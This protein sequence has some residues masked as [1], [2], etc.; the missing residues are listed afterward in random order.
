M[1]SETAEQSE[2]DATVW[3]VTM[4]LD[5]YIAGVDGAMNWVAGHG[6]AGPVADEI[7]DTTGAILAGRRWHDTAM[8][9]FS[10]R[11]GIY[12]GN[13]DGPVLV[14]TH[15]PPSDPPDREIKFVAG[16]IED[17]VAA[18]RDEA[19]GRR[20]GIF[21]AGVARQVLDA[22]LLDEIV[23]HIAPVLLGSGVRLYGDHG[24]STVVLQRTEAT[25]SPQLTDLRFRVVR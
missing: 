3:H 16:P 22:G 15:E 21:G 24:A 11:A 14:L 5:G 23:V 8:E 19:G 17:A 10:G 9:H 18:A 12:G 2:P 20:L 13:W 4:S 1:T 25:L 6:P 7:R